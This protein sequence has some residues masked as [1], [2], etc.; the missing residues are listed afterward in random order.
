MPY[1]QSFFR[2]ELNSHFYETFHGNAWRK[3]KFSLNMAIDERMKRPHSLLLQRKQHFVCVPHCLRINTYER[4]D[5]VKVKASDSVIQIRIVFMRLN[6]MEIRAAETRNIFVVCNP[7]KWLRNLFLFQ[8][9][10]VKSRSGHQLARN[11]YIIQPEHAR[12]VFG[13]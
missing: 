8:T 11:S 7:K 6:F 5:E 13:Y 3:Y 1:T 2:C 4:R 10:M 9:L 12:K